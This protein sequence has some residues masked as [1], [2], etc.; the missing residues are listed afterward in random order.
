MWWRGRDYI[1]NDVDLESLL[2]WKAPGKRQQLTHL[3]FRSLLTNHASLTDHTYRRT[4]WQRVYSKNCADPNALPVTSPHSMPRSLLEFPL[5]PGRR[6]TTACQI[7]FVLTKQ[8]THHRQ[9][10]ARRL[11]R[12]RNDMTGKFAFR[13]SLH[14]LNQSLHRPNRR[15]WWCQIVP[16]S[17]LTDVF[18]MSC[19]EGSHC[20]GYV[21]LG[22][23]QA[24][25]LLNDRATK[26]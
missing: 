12:Y 3:G 14:C 22:S 25:K 4:G 13:K 20:V 9:D 8:C 11:H 19:D 5:G 18:S 6:T 2:L 26:L 16:L 24:H 15:S 7:M 17:E 10:T 21:V 23:S 1:S